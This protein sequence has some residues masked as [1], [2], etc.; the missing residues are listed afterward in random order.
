MFLVPSR[1]CSTGDYEVRERRRESL[2]YKGQSFQ[3]PPAPLAKPLMQPNKEERRCSPSQPTPSAYPPSIH[4]HL[5][6]PPVREM[7]VAGR[8]KKQRRTNHGY[9]KECPQ[10]YFEFSSIGFF[11]N[12]LTILWTEFERLLNRSVVSKRA[13]YTML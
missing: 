4:A 7:R 3:H 1:R 8:G 12:K 13:I 11:S 5:Q 2:P 6:A 9:S 10:K